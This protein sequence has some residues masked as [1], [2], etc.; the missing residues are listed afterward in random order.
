MS[1]IESVPIHIVRRMEEE[2]NK[3]ETEVRSLRRE[4]EHLRRQLE[5]G[6]KAEAR[7]VIASGELK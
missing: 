5:D 1:E 2:N 4:V 7:A 3:L 6:Q